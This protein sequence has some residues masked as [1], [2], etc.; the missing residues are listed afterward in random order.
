MHTPAPQ[1]NQW[2]AQLTGRA[3]FWTIIVVLVAGV[4]IGRALFRR[5]PPPLPYLGRVPDFSLV[6]QNGA[7]FGSRE[8]VGRTWLGAALSPSDPDGDLIGDQLRKIQ[9]RAHNLGD[10]FHVISI[11]TDPEHDSPP[12]LDAFIRKE[13]GSPR[14]WR[15]L[16][17]DKKDVT[18][19]FA[20]FQPPGDAWRTHFVLVDPTMRVRAVYNARDP[21]V[22]E[23]VLFDVGLLVN[24]GG[25]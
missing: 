21:D 22:V 1:R 12:D 10:A 9:H 14:M 5:L 4:S 24:R 15:Y 11:T 16:T 25:S 3:W 17:G 2:L 7:P 23:R 18:D 8:L 20:R 6:D 19:L 13:H